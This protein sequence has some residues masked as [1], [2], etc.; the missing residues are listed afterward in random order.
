[1]CLHDLLL[2]ILA[3]FIHYIVT[4]RTFKSVRQRRAPDFACS[5]NVDLTMNAI[6]SVTG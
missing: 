4:A 1:M 5:P 6:T 3:F 2:C